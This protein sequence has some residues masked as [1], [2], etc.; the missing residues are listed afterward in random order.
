MN[1]A[2]I[3]VPDE[4]TI[5]TSAN[6]I[7]GASQLPL[8]PAQLTSA[9]TAAR[10]SLGVCEVQVP[11]GSAAWPAAIKFATPVVTG[12]TLAP[13]SDPTVLPTVTVQ[14]QPPLPRFC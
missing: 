12:P 9:T 10:G 6:P 13:G 7:T 8:H 2:V 11:D 3:L 1:M 14:L 5:Q 4:L